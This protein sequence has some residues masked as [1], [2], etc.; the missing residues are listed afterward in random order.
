MQWT[1]H[2]SLEV[3]NP[4][5][6]RY[7]EIFMWSNLIKICRST[8]KGSRVWRVSEFIFIVKGFSVCFVWMSLSVTGK[9]LKIYIFLLDSDDDSLCNSGLCETNSP[10]SCRKYLTEVFS[11]LPLA[12][13]SNSWLYSWECLIGQGHKLP[14]WPF[15]VSKDLICLFCWVPLT[16][17]L[18]VCMHV[19]HVCVCQEFL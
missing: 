17:Q 16:G 3:K 1:F 6:S 9:L 12:M 11:F 10:F 14:K 4:W 13:R 7:A 15:W 5:P 8:H 18:V 19:L 2:L